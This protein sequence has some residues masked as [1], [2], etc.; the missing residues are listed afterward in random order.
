MSIYSREPMEASR[1]TDRPRVTSWPPLHY[2][3]GV[4]LVVLAK[5][6]FIAVTKR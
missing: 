4:K 3:M 1:A 2:V 6:S 5:T